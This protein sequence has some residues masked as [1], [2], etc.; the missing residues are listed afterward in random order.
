MSLSSSSALNEFAMHSFKAGLDQ[1]AIAACDI[2]AS[3]P[4]HCSRRRDGQ[5][6]RRAKC[7]HRATHM[8][9]SLLTYVSPSLSMPLNFKHARRTRFHGEF[10]W[11]SA[12][13]R[14]RLVGCDIADQGS[15]VVIRYV[16]A[17]LITIKKYDV[18]VDERRTHLPEPYSGKAVC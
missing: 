5:C 4:A 12:M 9:A 1:R 18:S 7:H 17:L 15:S 8:S 14:N 6:H 10:H 16:N 3:V 2:A 11:D 13:K